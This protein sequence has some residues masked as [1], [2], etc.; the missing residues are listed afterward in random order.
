MWMIS[1]IIS[2]LTSIFFP[3]YCYIC[4]K[5]GLQEQ[6]ICESCIAKL[7]PAIDTPA[8]YVSSLFSFK[9]PAVKKII[10][11]IK[12][13]HRKDLIAPLALK[14]AHKIAKKENMATY[15]LVPIPMPK[16][17][18]Y[19]RGY[20]HDE[21]L[22]FAIAHH[23]KLSARTD[24]LIRNPL[25]NK[26]RQVLTKSRSERLNNQHDMFIVHSDLAGMSIIL[27]DDVATT[28]AT[29]SEARRVLLQHGAGSV[30]AFT[31]AH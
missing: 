13:F 25:K 1:T 22:V 15:A 6:S 27:I 17:R 7:K 28:G 12:Y 29:L 30:E 2:S 21:A 23:T 24:I 26:K 16:F 8:P 11:A 4:K 10:H 31:I 20:N 18:S 3:T 5:E 19:L 14:I 9:D